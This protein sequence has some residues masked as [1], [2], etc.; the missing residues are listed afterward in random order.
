MPRLLSR[1]LLPFL[2]LG[3]P[4]YNRVVG[5]RVPL[6]F[7][8][9]NR[10]VGKKGTPYH[11]GATG[12]PRCCLHSHV[13]CPSTSAFDC[14]A[15]YDHWQAVHVGLCE[16]RP[17]VGKPV[18]LRTN[19]YRDPTSRALQKE[20]CSSGVCLSC[21]VLIKRHTSHTRRLD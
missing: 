16:C 13:A 21:V 1:A 18:S 14:D 5:K 11:E 6:L 17:G 12:E 20:N 10:V 4:Y 8:Y 15:Q 3:F 9:Y 2:F 19:D 7:P